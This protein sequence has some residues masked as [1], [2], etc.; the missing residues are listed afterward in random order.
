MKN[1]KYIVTVILLL[2]LLISAIFASSNAK[3]YDHTSIRNY[4][5]GLFNDN[6]NCFIEIKDFLQ[7]LCKSNTVSGTKSSSDMVNI[8]I[9]N[10]LSDPHS[11]S[12]NIFT[13]EIKNGS[14]T[15][16]TNH[17]EI[18]SPNDESVCC[19]LSTLF[20]AGIQKI[21]ADYNN[22]EINSVMFIL[23][24]SYPVAKGHA[25]ISINWYDS[26][27]ANSQERFISHI[28]DHWY[29]FDQVFG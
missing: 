11:I 16:Q 5:I 2:V 20:N 29:Y 1:N 19:S 17:H 3:S 13:A 6:K 9:L 4:S 21:E 22:S 7:D 26:E 15:N 12:M 28:E 23:N 8:T 24:N 14:L 18:V 25:V 27:R 10:D